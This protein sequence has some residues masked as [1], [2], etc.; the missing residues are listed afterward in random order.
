M[1]SVIWSIK[2]DRI[3]SLIKEGKRIDGRRLDEYR[4]I[5]V[6]KNIS[7][8]ANGSARVTLGKTEVLVGI[9]MVPGTPYPDNPNQGTISVGTELLPLA[10][11]EFEVG[12]P[13]EAAIELARV[14]ERGIR[15]SKT[16][17]FMTLCVREG[18]L[19]WIV[20]IDT[21]VDRKSVV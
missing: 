3:V 20:F 18:E 10:S 21:Y 1:E 16:I 4:K 15:E 2:A 6:E 8:N 14:V 17:D 7:D 5:S 13:R 12:P 19:V 11:P 9:K